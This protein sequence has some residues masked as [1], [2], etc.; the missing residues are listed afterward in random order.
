MIIKSL[1][2]KT[3]SGTKQLLQY[4]FKKEEKLARNA[5]QKPLVIR[6]NV[7]SRSIEK[8][9]SE[10]KKNE[11]LRIHKRSDMVRAYHTIISLS[12][13]DKEH[14]TEKTLRGIAAEFM[15]QRGP[16]NLY[17]AVAHWD[18]DHVHMHLVSSGTKYLTGQA[19]RISRL[20]FQQLKIGM[21][22]YQQKKHPELINSLPRH[23]KGKEPQVDRR[24]GRVSQ[25]D[26]LLQSLQAAYTKSR[27]TED[28]LTA[29]RSAGHEP[30]YRAGKLTGVKFE[31]DG[32]KFRLNRMGYDKE[33]ID[34]LDALQLKDE[35]ALDELNEIRGRTNSSREI[36]EEENSRIFEDDTA[37]MDE[38][39]DSD[40]MHENNN[41]DE[42]YNEDSEV[43]DD[44]S[45][46]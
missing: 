46:N 16:D 43:D 31:A 18:K 27:S 12:N 41:D 9:G 6:K 35:K 40:T 11:A 20:E 8:W 34:K 2:V 14:I 1:S 33:K 44:E 45:L 25:K 21:D 32:R 10:F 36:D 3:N 5:K 39:R 37:K 13:K 42:D 17:I 22:L 24:N 7:R 23:G 38:E 28:F 19:N 30:Y 26:T 15:K 4:L 29:L